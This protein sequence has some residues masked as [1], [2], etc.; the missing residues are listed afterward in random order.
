MAACSR[1]TVKQV[2][3]FN[4]LL[5]D[6]TKWDL[7]LDSNGNIALAAPP[8]ALEQDVASAVRLF[9]G[10]LWYDTTKGIPYFE[11]ILGQLPPVSLVT[12]YIEKA[13][14]SVPGVVSARCVISSFQNRS[15]AGE[16]QFI[17]DSGIGG[18]IGF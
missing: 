14:L 13:A 15:V 12:A 1:E 17:D 18:T 5:L 10:E 9:L 11:E 6:R 7:V 8:Y 3:Q 16:I 4:T 2:S